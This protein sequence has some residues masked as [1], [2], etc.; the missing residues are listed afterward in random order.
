MGA[1]LMSGYS[2]E[3]QNV[4]VSR[5]SWGASLLKTAEQKALE[6]WLEA[7][8]A[9]ILRRQSEMPVKIPM[10]GKVV[11]FNLACQCFAAYEDGLFAW[12]G[13][14]PLHGKISSGKRD[15]ETPTGVFTIKWKNKNHWSKKYDAPMPY[16]AFFTSPGIAVHEGNIFH[17]KQSHGCIRVS[18]KMARLLWGKFGWDGTKV[19]VV[20]HISKLADVMN[21]ATQ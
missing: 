12:R 10:M 8:R 14:S 6:A 15:Y 19:V 11:V 17:P 3:T 7:E 9:L 18:A 16:A 4:E 1:L 5:F 13:G 20:Q 21:Q 2:A